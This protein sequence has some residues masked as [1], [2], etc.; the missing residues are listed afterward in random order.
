MQSYVSSKTTRL[1]TL[2]CVITTN[3]TASFLKQNLKL[4]VELVKLLTE[5]RFEWSKMFALLLQQAFGKS[6]FPLQ[7]VQNTLLIS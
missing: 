5:F 2:M 7:P 6:S 4:Y 3:T 1:A